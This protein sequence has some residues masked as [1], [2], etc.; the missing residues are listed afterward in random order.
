[1]NWVL[2]D[3]HGC[4]HTLKKLVERVKSIDSHASLIFVGDYVDRGPYNR[5]VIDY[6]IELQNE[7]A[8][9]LRGN[10]DDIICWMLH[11]ECK[12]FLSELLCGTPTVESVV[13]WWLINGFGSTLKSYDR[14]WETNCTFIL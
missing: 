5:E 6:C 4:Y 3:V 9:C 10:H 1:M 11:K 7:G 2:S 8:I 13:E 14:D 12:T